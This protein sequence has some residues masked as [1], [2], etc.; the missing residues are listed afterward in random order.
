[1]RL[2]VVLVSELDHKSISELRERGYR[3]RGIEPK[4]F[5]EEG[6]EVDGFYM[7]RRVEDPEP[8]G[9]P[10][11]FRVAAAFSFPEPRATIVSK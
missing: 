5:G 7:A 10:I 9:E 3:I 11:A 8:F 2:D 6:A 1:M 4:A